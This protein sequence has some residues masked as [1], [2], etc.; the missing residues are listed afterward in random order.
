MKDPCQ[1]LAIIGVSIY[2]II[3]QE[4][5][6]AYDVDG[7]KVGKIS[8]E[9]AKSDNP[10]VYH[11]GV[12]IWFVNSK[13]EVLVQQR[14]KNM[15]SPLKWSFIGGHVDYGEDSLT[16]CVRE[17]KE[18]IGINVPKENFEFQF[19][20]IRENKWQI[21]ETFIANLDTSIAEM[22][23]CPN[24]IEQVKWLSLD[25]LKG[26]LFSCEFLAHDDEYKQRIYEILNNRIKGRK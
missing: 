3:M 24:E 18:E 1:S 7:N 9:E 13:G 15:P 11:K 21:A 5:L 23:L 25:D 20:I 17:T 8:I 16:T 22:K 12:W 14:S 10:G 2:I 4:Y 19:K 6:T 26:L